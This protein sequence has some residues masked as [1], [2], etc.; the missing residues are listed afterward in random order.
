MRSILKLLHHIRNRQHKMVLRRGLW[1]WNTTDL[2]TKADYAKQFFID[3]QSA[4]ITDVFLYTQATT[5]TG[6]TTQMKTLVSKATSLNIKCWGLDGARSYFADSNGAGGLNKNIDAMI[7]YNGKV[8]AAEKFTGFQ[9]DCEPEDNTKYGMSFHDDIPDSKLSKTGGG[10]WQK[11]AALD[12]EM[13]MRNWLDMHQSLKTKLK[14][15]GLLLGAAIPSWTD[16]YYGEPLSA[17]WNGVRQSVM[18][19]FVGILDTMNIMSYQTDTAKIMDRIKGEVTYASTQTGNPGI[20]VYG[21]V[22]TV[23]GRGAA[24]TYGD[25][26]T[27]NKKSAVLADIGKIDTAMAG[28]SAYGGMNI[29]DYVGWKAL[30]A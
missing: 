3:C 24:V 2:L 25:H 29:H 17:T 18:K 19:H 1:V 6:Y 27:K 13:L 28:Y 7:S 23:R 15:N 9:T 11:T 30:V 10:K 26:S 20:K 8:S 22:E 5:F 16:T 4:K 21:G 12:R 14:A